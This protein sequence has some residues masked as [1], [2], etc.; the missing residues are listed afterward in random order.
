MR[1]V[2][3]GNYCKPTC[4]Y[5]F[6]KAVI[7]LHVSMYLS[8]VLCMFLTLF[9]FVTVVMLMVSCDHC[10]TC[11]CKY[12]HAFFVVLVLFFIACTCQPCVVQ[13]TAS[14]LCT[15]LFLLRMCLRIVKKDYQELN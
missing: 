10:W 5:V 15:K 3:V 9:F 1:I 2:G 6:V 14:C 12:N 7:Y 13:E 11:T 4:Q 8:V